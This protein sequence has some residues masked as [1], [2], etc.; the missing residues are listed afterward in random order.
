MVEFEQTHGSERDPSVAAWLEEGIDEAYSSREGVDSGIPG[1][2]PTDRVVQ[3]DAQTVAEVLASYADNVAEAMSEVADEVQQVVHDVAID[4]QQTLEDIVAPEDQVSANGE[5]VQLAVART[6]PYLSNGVPSN[7]ATVNPVF[8]Q[9]YRT[10]ERN[11][12]A[13]LTDAET[14]E[15]FSLRGYDSLEKETRISIESPCDIEHHSKGGF[16]LTG[17]TQ[18][19]PLTAYLVLAAAVVGLSSIGPLLNVQ[20]GVDDTIKTLWRNSATACA[21]FPL[22]LHSVFL[23]G[24]PVLSPWQC[25][26]LVLSG[27]F[28]SLYTA[29]FAWAVQYTTIG[30]TVIF[31]N[32][33]AIILLIGKTIMGETLS[34]AEALGSLTAFGG[35]VLCSRD[36]AQDDTG[37]TSSLW[38]DGFALLCAFCG[39]GYLVT[40]KTIRP[41]MNLYVF[42]WSVMF[43]ASIGNLTLAYMAGVE[44]TL[45]RDVNHGAFGWLNWEVNRFPLEVVMVISCQFFGALGK[46]PDCLCMQT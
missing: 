6:T 16:P 45:D 36:S 2:A 8:L 33:Q 38:G 5:T 1:V 10:F 12:T 40:A 22:A 30:N 29:L 17:E 41:Y 32:T 23:D 42:M 46:F 9:E 43:W 28:Y 39:V 27:A 31:S 14:V 44:V 4:L 15:T 19:T 3:Q 25:V 26:V 21:L 7:Q 13:S 20:F 34:W 37:T 35:A 11:D 24:F 18:E